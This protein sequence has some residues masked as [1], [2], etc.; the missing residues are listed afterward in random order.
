MRAFLASNP[1]CPT[2][3][4]CEREHITCGRQNNAHPP[5]PL[6]DIPILIPGPY[7]YITL[8]DN[9]EGRPGCN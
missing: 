4:L 2:C 1:S 7:K 8:H 6:Q 5:P 3:Q 9:G